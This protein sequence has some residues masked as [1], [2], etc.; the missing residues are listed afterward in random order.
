MTDLENLERLA[1]LKDEDP[2]YTDEWWA[3]RCKLWT[4]E[5]TD[6]YGY[7]YTSVLAELRSGERKR[8]ASKTEVCRDLD[9]TLRTLNKYLDTDKPLRHGK[10]IGCYFYT[11]PKE[12]NYEG[13]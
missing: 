9:L 11:L 10:S 4:D 2:S 7:Q 5:E 3:L 12:E 1:Y 13:Y 6:K 8:Y